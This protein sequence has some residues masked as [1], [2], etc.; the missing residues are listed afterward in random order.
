MSRKISG[1]VLVKGTLRSETP[2]SVGGVGAGE[3]DFALAVN[4]KGEYYIP[5][6]GLAGPMRHWF[7]RRVKDNEDLARKLFGFQKQGTD[8]GRASMLTVKDAP[9]TLPAGMS[10]ERRDGIGIDRVTGGT[11]T[12]IKFDRAVLPRGSTIGLEME[13]DLP[14]EENDTMLFKA[15]LRRILDALCCGEIPLGASKTRGLGQVRMDSVKS[16]SHDFSGKAGL[17]SW[18]RSSGPTAENLDTA[19]PPGDSL[20]LEPEQSLTVTIEWEA[21]GP[22]MVKS[23]A[24]GATVDIVPL[25]GAVSPTDVAAVFPG[26][27]IKGALRSRTETIIRTVKGIDAEPVNDRKGFLDQQ[28]D[29]NLGLVT[30]LFGSTEQ[31]GRLSIPDI[32]QEASRISLEDYLQEQFNDWGRKED[33]V[34][35]DRFTGGASKGALYSILAP[36]EGKWPDMIIKVRFGRAPL[37][38]STDPCREPVEA[39]ISLLLFAL[40]DLAAGWI[41]LGFG[42]MRGMG[43]VKVNGIK[44]KQEGIEG[45]EKEFNLDDI[46]QKGSFQNL[47]NAWQAEMTGEGK[48]NE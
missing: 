37:S 10:E 26:S 44:I 9:V 27:S 28:N 2:I 24:E 47:N 39:M 15:A 18:L 48:S 16:E 13:M 33:H 20:E 45:L 30:D 46:R 11:A 17:L 29:T 36:R 34:A 14:P 23:G 43:N 7:E 6:T 40:R 12:A 21:D 35:I 19:L 5:G 25:V 1:K 41:P 32:Y 38:G 31:A 22:V 4:G 42:T 3:T 8:E